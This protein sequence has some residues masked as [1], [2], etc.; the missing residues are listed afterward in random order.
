[1]GSNESWTLPSTFLGLHFLD[2]RRRRGHLLVLYN[3]NWIILVESLAAID[4]F[5]C[6]F[7]FKGAPLQKRVWAGSSLW[8]PSFPLLEQGR[9]STL[10]MAKIGRH[11]Y[12]A[13]GADT[14]EKWQWSTTQPRSGPN[15]LH[16]ELNRTNWFQKAQISSN[17]SWTL[18][19][20]FSGLH[21]FL[22]LHRICI[23]GAGI[24]I[25]L[26]QKQIFQKRLYQ[27]RSR[28]RGFHKA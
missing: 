20:N 17:E 13:L 7:V 21:F 15:R 2:L 19:S 11:T 6:L 18:S 23:V 26:L 4:S 28:T 1:M 3:V 5:V 25:T 14:Q 8:G 10:P 27:H 12:N 16:E 9:H 24:Y 22:D